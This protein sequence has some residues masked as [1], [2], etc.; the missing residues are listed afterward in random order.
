MQ[1]GFLLSVLILLSCTDLSSTQTIPRKRIFPFLALSFPEMVGYK[2][3]LDNLLLTLCGLLDRLISASKKWVTTLISVLTKN[4]CWVICR[5]L[6]LA[7]GAFS[8]WLYDE[9]RACGSRS[10]N[11]CLWVEVLLRIVVLL[12]TLWHVSMMR[13]VF[14][15][16]SCAHTECL[17]ACHKFVEVNALG[18][19]VAAL[20]SY[21]S[22][23]RAA[24]YFV[25]ASFRS[26]LEGARFR[27][28]KQ[29]QLSSV[30]S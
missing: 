17:V 30:D 13:W 29:V 21:D 11:G 16:F 8:I 25:L 24:A 15:F 6:L 1:V 3:S 5:M 4:Y 2:I 10:R 12:Y 19:T 18:L 7:E 23:M 14:F 26:H 27:E 22:N 9:T 20:S 28:Q